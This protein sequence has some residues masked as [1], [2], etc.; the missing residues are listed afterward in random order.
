[1]ISLRQ[2]RAARALLGWSQQM[3]ADK[4]LLSVKAV[5]RLER[6][7]VTS[8]AATVEALERTLTQAGII[9]IPAGHGLG[10]GVQLT[11]DLLPVRA[12]ETP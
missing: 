8:H 4:A 7:E 11:S 6:N 3:L 12:E 5:A 1:M 10:E 9:F 2:I